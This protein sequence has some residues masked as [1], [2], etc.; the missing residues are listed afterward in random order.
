MT[1]TT[2][3]ALSRVSSHT[4]H[5]VLLAITGETQL[6]E[7][8]SAMPRRQLWL[9]EGLRIAERQ[10]GLLRWQLDAAETPALPTE[11]LTRLRFVSVTSRP[12]LAKSGLVTHTDSGWVI[13]LNADEA[14]VR[15]RFSAC[16]EL[17]HLIDHE[18]SERAERGLYR[19]AYGES[20]EQLAERVC[21]RFAAALLM[22]KTLLRRDWTSGLQQLAGLARRYQVSKAAMEVRLREIGLI[23]PTPRCGF[24]T[25]PAT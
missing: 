2:G 15:Q 10:A 4:G 16:H 19:G 23:E 21:D 6:R 11:T 20:P 14:A 7:L 18:L 9:D 24:T 17:K 13:V 8:R 12:R 25:R 22:P 1:V 3:I 5:D